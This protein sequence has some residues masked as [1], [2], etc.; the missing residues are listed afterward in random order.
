MRGMV[1][2]PSSLIENP[3]KMASA[4]EF[5][6]VQSKNGAHHLDG[7]YTIFGRVT[8]GMNTVDKIAAAQTDNLDWPLENIYIKKVE[9]IE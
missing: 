9:I 4:F 1:S 2:M 3:Y 7:N 6:I 8:S 5:F